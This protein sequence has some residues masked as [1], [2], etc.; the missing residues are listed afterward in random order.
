MSSDGSIVKLIQKAESCSFEDAA[1]LYRAIKDSFTN[2]YKNKAD[3]RATDTE[4]H[5]FDSIIIENPANNDPA[6]VT[7][8]GS[9]ASSIVLPEASGTVTLD[10]NVTTLSNKVL[11]NTTT[12][13]IK[14]GQ[15]NILD[16]NVISRNVGFDS[17]GLT[18][19][20]IY[21][22][23]DDS[24]TIRLGYPIVM[25]YLPT[26]QSITNA[27]D[28]VVRFTE[29]FNNSNGAWSDITWEYTMPHTGLYEIYGSLHYQSSST[30]TRE[31]KA[32]NPDTM[33]VMKLGFNGN[34]SSASGCYCTGSIIYYGNAGDHIQFN[35]YQTSGGNKQLLGNDYGQAYCKAFIKYV[36]GYNL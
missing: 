28:N 20:Q 16:D 22:L 8:N 13:Q 14:A 3:E 1:L 34:P 25:L 29:I 36:E 35:A 17:T 10:D 18:T 6:T 31:I 27:A 23:P 12:L 15:F 21:K 24:G 30:G 7:Y 19:S 5:V 26:N 32:Y 2:Q 33:E 11:D 9:S 4:N